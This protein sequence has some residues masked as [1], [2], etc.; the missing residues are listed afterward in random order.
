M[1]DSGSAVASGDA[2]GL[3]GGGKLNPP[4]IPSSAPVP[5]P[6]GNTDSITLL[7]TFSI[8]AS[9]RMNT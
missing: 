5:S 9:L 3:D 6:L 8:I 1:A 4:L 7:L 2:M